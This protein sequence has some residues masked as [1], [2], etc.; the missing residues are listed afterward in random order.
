M[1]AT[2]GTEGSGARGPRE[3]WQC[4]LCK[5]A[6][7]PHVEACPFLVGHGSAGQPD[8]YAD[9]EVAI[10]GKTLWRT[11]Q[12]AQLRHARQHPASEPHPDSLFSHLAKLR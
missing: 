9:V 11:V 12:A 10:D 8:L 4:P 5:R 6:L 3:G 1:T 2:D 7:A